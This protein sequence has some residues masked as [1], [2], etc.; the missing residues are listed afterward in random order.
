[1]LVD[2]LDRQVSQAQLE[3]ELYRQFI[4][5]NQHPQSTADQQ[6]SLQD[7]VD[8][9]KR[10]EEKWMRA[11]QEVQSQRAALQQQL[12]DLD[13]QERQLDLMEQQYWHANAQYESQLMTE[14]EQLQSLDRQLDY[15]SSHLEKLRK[16]NVYNDAFHIWHDGPFGTI[17]GFR[18]GRLPDHPVEWTEINAAWGQAV[19]L[20]SLLA[21]KMGY[22]FQQYRL[23]PLG[24]FS[25]IEKMHQDRAVYEMYAHMNHDMCAHPLD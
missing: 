16:A 14:Y 4:A 11:L 9:L 10:E 1:M 15:T 22:T 19:L 8:E 7:D 12:L 2:T 6:T 18:L 23:V 17:N 21:D 20:L 25:R 13:Q 3:S 24:S 5:Q